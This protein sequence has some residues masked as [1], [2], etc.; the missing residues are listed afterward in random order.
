MAKTKPIGVRFD[1]DLLSEL[2][3]QGV[4][5]TPQKA[6]NYISEF[7]KKNRKDKDWLL[8]YVKETHKKRQTKVINLTPDPTPTNYTINTTNKDEILKQIAD[9]RAEKIPDG[10]NTIMGRKSWNLEQAEKIKSLQKQ[11]F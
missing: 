8:N 2:K 10:R 7:Y 3:E 9:I 1:Q 4:A 5:N 11:L 6:L